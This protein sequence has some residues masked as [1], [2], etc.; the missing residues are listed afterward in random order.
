MINK[1]K[2]F[3]PRDAPACVI[4]EK[5][6]YFV[7]GAQ[8][9]EQDSIY[10]IR[11]DKLPHHDQYFVPVMGKAPP[12]IVGI[13]ETVPG[14]R[15]P[16]KGRKRVKTGNAVGERQYGNIEH[17]MKLLYTFCHASYRQTASNSHHEQAA[18]QLDQRIGT[19]PGRDGQTYS[20]S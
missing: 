9:F 17:R 5:G 4:V 11:L 20:G 15:I 2:H 14:I 6:Y 7:L 18:R 8:L 16:Q 12:G 19:P 13:P 1:R 3:Q 10:C